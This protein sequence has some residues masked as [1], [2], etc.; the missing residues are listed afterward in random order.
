MTN[1]KPIFIKYIYSLFLVVLPII[2]QYSIGSFTFLQLFSLFGFVLLLVFFRKEKL[3]FSISLVVFIVYTVF[4]ILLFS[5]ND[6]DYIRLSLRIFS[7]VLLYVNFFVVAPN[8]IDLRFTIKTYGFLAFLSSALLLG[9]YVFY[10][11]S[12]R[13]T[14]LLINNV[15]LNYGGGINSNTLIESTT[16]ITYYFRP[17]SIFIEPIY[18]AIYI[19]PLIII[20]LF[21]CQ[22]SIKH[23]LMILMMCFAVMLSASF[24][25]VVALIIVFLM[26]LI[27][28][29][30]KKKRN[31]RLITFSVLIVFLASFMFLLTQ[32]SFYVSLNNKIASMSDATSTSSFSLRIVR[33]FYCFSQFDIMNQLFGCGYGNIAGY[34]TENGI[35]TVLD[36]NIDEI[37]YMNGFMTLVCSTGIVGTVFYCFAICWLCNSFK[38]NRDVSIPLF[39]FA[40]LLLIATAT[41]DTDKYLLSI[42]LISC[43]SKADLKKESS[44]AAV[45]GKKFELIRN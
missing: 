40:L 8:F 21:Y 14:M 34:L 2:N 13:T 30:L 23:Y 7:F 5:F 16:R 24:F 25:G 45:A 38:G 12:G 37:A 43:F 18:F 20:R 3:Y 42:V 1:K 4:S 19:I 35:S 27:Y 28:L 41:F 29:H 17:T 33:G 26:Y 31:R 22:N 11:V 6:N 10:L 39:V 32:K 9:Q 36:S 44:L 15:T